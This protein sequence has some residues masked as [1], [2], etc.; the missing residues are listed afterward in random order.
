MQVLAAQEGSDEPLSADEIDW[1]MEGSN[2]TDMP[3]EEAFPEIV[4]D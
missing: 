4:E 1:I 2:S 3:I